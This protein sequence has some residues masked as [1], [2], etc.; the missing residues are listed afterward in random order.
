MIQ[1]GKRQKAFQ[2]DMWLE[3]APVLSKGHVVRV[4]IPPCLESVGTCVL[5]RECQFG[6]INESPR[7]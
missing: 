4:Q 2:K 3:T 7:W 1:K 6:R 5:G